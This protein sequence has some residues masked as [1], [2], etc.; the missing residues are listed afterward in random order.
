MRSSIS[1][2]T[3]WV[4][5]IALQGWLHHGWPARQAFWFWRDRK[6][7]AGN[8]LSPFAN[9]LFLYGASRYAL[10]VRLGLEPWLSRTCEA[11][12]AIAVVQTGFRMHAAALIY[13]WP[14]AALAPVRA[15]WGNVVNFA[16][17]ATA[18]WDF[19]ESRRRGSGLAWRKT[20]HDYPVQ[21]AVLAGVSAYGEVPAR[22]RVQSQAPG[23]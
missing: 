6:G 11:T 9:L 16:A 4:T 5:G 10:G 23:I 15:L 3:R 2:R 22:P 7:I 14:F 1:Q 19:F 8:L 20:D 21:V 18:L 17:T 13:G 12:C